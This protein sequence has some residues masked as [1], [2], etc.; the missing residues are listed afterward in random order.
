M[1]A[2]FNHRRLPRCGCTVITR[3]G[4]VRMKLGWRIAALLAVIMYVLLAFAFAVVLSHNLI[5][6]LVICCAAILLVYA[7]WLLFTGTGR[8]TVQGLLGAALGLGVFTAA[9]VYIL[10]NTKNRRA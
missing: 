1:L 8:R 2:D 10:T 4:A 5:L 7:G 3:G 6:T 9:V